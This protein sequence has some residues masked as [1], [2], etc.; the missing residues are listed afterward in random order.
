MNEIIEGLDGVEVIADDFLICGYGTS[1]DEAIASH[2]TNLRLFLD[3]ARERGLKLNPDKVKLQLDSVPFIGHL[4]TSKGLAADPDKVSSIV[5]IPKPTN[6]KSLQQLLG[7]A[8]YLSKFL[9]Q[10]SAVSNPLQQLERK[11]TECNWSEIHDEAKDKK[12]YL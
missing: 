11:D 7:M 9:P 8:Q 3:R 12:S 6:I 1:T 10:L 5:N 4:L 2:D